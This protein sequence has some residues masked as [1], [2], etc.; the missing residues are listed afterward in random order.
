MKN[1]G[2]TQQNLFRNGFK[3]S[4]TITFTFENKPRYS[5]QHIS[6]SQKNTCRCCSREEGSRAPRR[7][8]RGT[9]S[10]PHQSPRGS[11]SCCLQ[12]GWPG[13]ET[14]DERGIRRRGPRDDKWTVPDKHERRFSP[15]GFKV[16]QFRVLVIKDSTEVDRH[17]L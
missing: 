11:A 5:Q 13:N 14:S 7:P 6:F 3:C 1:H 17:T 8:P 15:G 4:K 12:P 9:C 16:A 10:W 2:P